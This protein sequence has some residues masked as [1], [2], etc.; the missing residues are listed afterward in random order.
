MARRRKAIGFPKV[1]MV[2][3][4]VWGV[5]TLALV[6]PALA[7][8]RDSKPAAR[9]PLPGGYNYLIIAPPGLKSSA[10]VWGMYRRERGYQAK[11]YLTGERA[12][13]EE[14]RW[15][16]H[17]VYQRS[18]RPY[19][20]YVLLLGHAHPGSLFPESYLPTDRLPLRP[21]EAMLWKQDKAA[22]DNGYARDPTTAEWLPIAIG[23]VPAP[24]DNY[25]L[26]VLGRVER[27]ETQP[28]VGDGR[29]RVEVV[30]SSSTW[31]TLIDRSLE[32]LL[33]R[34]VDELLPSYVQAHVLNGNPESAYHY[35]LKGLQAETARRFDSGA[36]LVSYIGHGSKNVLT[37]AVDENG[38]ET[39]LFSINDL[40]R[41]QNA[42]QSVMTF[43]ACNVGQFD[44]PGG[45]ISLAEALLLSENGPVATYAASRI[46]FPLPNSMLEKDLLQLMFQERVATVGE[47]LRQVRDAS[48]QPG[49]DKSLAIWIGRKLTPYLYVV[50]T[51]KFGIGKI[52]PKSAYLWQR[53]AYNLFGDPALALAYPQPELEIKP[54]MRWMPVTWRVYFSGKSKPGQVVV[55]MLNYPAATTPAARSKSADRRVVYTDA[56]NKMLA[57]TITIA[58]EKGRFKGALSLPWGTA[59]GRYVLQALSTTEKETQVGSTEVRLGLP[60]IEML[61]STPLVWLVVSVVL[62]VRLARRRQ[63]GQP[64]D[65]QR[66]RSITAPRLSKRERRNFALVH[67]PGSV[68]TLA[69]KRMDEPDSLAVSD[70]YWHNKR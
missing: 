51:G 58:D 43:V 12:T 63:P 19:P 13:T 10:Q 1:R 60:Q 26:N 42:S 59:P 44:L 4:A 9:P 30:A 31:G 17:Q 50:T 23:R 22:G 53:Y 29:A 56:N 27:Y 41:V 40:Y 34:Y 3:M 21:A 28:P 68:R 15:I 39:R 33:S 69:R 54:L 66:L 35:P 55:V 2:W 65:D 38:V 62:A 49:I 70:R 11:V 67:D 7:G 52:S 6:W 36:L 14:I 5:L 46:T 8:W 61:C 20:F 45:Q 48:D 25:A 47:W 16:I 57:G 24:D 37:P 64:E 18:G 32:R